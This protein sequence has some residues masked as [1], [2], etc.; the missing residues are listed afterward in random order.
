MFLLSL[1]YL[2]Q[3][4]PYHLVLTAVN[5]VAAPLIAWY[6]LAKLFFITLP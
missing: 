3:R 4:D 2:H 6:V 5:T 1:L